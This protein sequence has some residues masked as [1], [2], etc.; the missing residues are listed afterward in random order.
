MATTN[1][2]SPQGLD[3]QALLGSALEFKQ[4]ND[5]A[6]Q[7][8]VSNSKR[9]QEITEAEA[10]L[11]R[12][13]GD[14][15]VI[16]DSARNTA[17]LDTQNSRV[18]A[19]TALGTNLKASGEVLTALSQSIQ[20]QYAERE[21]ALTEIERKKNISLLEDP[22]GWINAQIN[23]NS[24]I[25]RHNIADARLANATAQYQELNKLTQSA[26][27]TQNAIDE[28]I[29]AASVKASADNT[30]AAAELK[31]KDEE[32]KGLVYNSD[33]IKAAL[34][35]ANNKFSA[36]NTIFSARKAEESSRVALAHLA[37]SREKF[38]W[39]KEEKDKGK[40]ADQFLIDKIN[41]GA[42]LRMGEAAEI[43]LP[44]SVRANT[45]LSLLKSNSPAGKQFQEDYMIADQSAVAGTKILAPSPARAIEVLNTMPVKLAPI[46]EQVRAVLEEAKNA[47]A[48]Q[49]AAGTIDGK[50]RDAVNTALNSTARAMVEAQARKINSPDNIFNIPTVRTLIKDSPVV[51]NLAITKKLLAPL[52]V[53]GSDLS[54]PDQVFSLVAKGLQDKT[55][56]YPEALELSTIYQTGVGVNM[57]ERQL[58][59]LGL[60]PKWSYNV[61]VTVDNTTPF[62]GKQIVDLTKPDAL[63]RAFNKYLVNQAQVEFTKELFVRPTYKTGEMAGGIKYAP[64][65][66]GNTGKPE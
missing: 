61:P 2:A 52:A 25:D 9:A 49:I 38:S 32:I 37:M 21:S 27:V 40:Q 47:V 11:Y 26:V 64:S 60:T 4:S 16:I 36:N 42:R 58:P 54:N 13:M 1:S 22:L 44:G 19:A 45:V 15:A 41:S 53:A 31:A 30:R 59:S 18:R 12:T 14:T 17:A 46:Q 65:G 48:G 20:I 62:N 28:S 39:E 7:G 33:G 55:I 5:Q 66:F 57:E 63:G 29:T 50:N 56:S 3:I 43:I 35:G 8:L 10:E 23:M 24:D 34:A 6:T 51:A